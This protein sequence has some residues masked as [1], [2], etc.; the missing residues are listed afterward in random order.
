MK[1]SDFQVK[2]ETK[3]KVIAWLSLQKSCELFISLP[4]S[5][6][7]A[8]YASKLERIKLALTTTL[9]FLYRTCIVFN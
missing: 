1:T 2:T 8:L 6:I 7:F 3:L 9:Y 4:I 5:L